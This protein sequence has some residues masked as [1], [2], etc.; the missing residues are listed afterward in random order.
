MLERKGG[1]GRSDDQGFDDPTKYKL[2]THFQFY[3]NFKELPCPW[4]KLCNLQTFH[5]SKVVTK[6]I[7]DVA[8]S[9]DV[10]RYLLYFLCL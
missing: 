2:Y 7:L 5:T 9:P 4:E 8:I 10:L 1:R 6:I 3:S